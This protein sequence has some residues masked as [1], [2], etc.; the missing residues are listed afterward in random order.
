M[1]G[2]SL[3]SPAFREFD[4]YLFGN[5]ARGVPRERLATLDTT[6]FTIAGNGAIESLNLA[7]AVNMCVYELTRERVN[8]RAPPTGDVR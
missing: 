3:Q 6:P 8:L 7:S 4:C 1:Q 5:E 2:G